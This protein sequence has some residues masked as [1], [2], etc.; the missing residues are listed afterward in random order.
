M[1]KMVFDATNR[2]PARL[3]L[4]RKE[5]SELDPFCRHN[6]RSSRLFLSRKEEEEK[7]KEGF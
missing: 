6:V 4:Y 2:H 7:K 1:K 3:L 5:N